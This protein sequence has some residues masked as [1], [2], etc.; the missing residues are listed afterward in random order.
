MIRHGESHGLNILREMRNA[1]GCF[2]TGIAVVT[3]CRSDGSKTGMTINSFTSVSLDPPL[4][5]WCLSTNSSSIDVFRDSPCFA[6]NVLSASQERI[7]KRFAQS[8]M[9]K[10]KGVA[11]FSGLG[12]APLLEGCCAWFECQTEQQYSVGDHVMMIGRVERFDY[13]KVEPLIYHGGLYRSL[14]ETEATSIV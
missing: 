5:A 7:S 11:T 3:A 6:I 10:F 4:I 8:S 14:N 2:A 12:G 1:L 13:R 9:D